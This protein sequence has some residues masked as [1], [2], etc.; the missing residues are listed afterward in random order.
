MKN[1]WIILGLLIAGFAGIFF[2]LHK[3]GT[4]SEFDRRRQAHLAWKQSAV[5]PS[6]VRPEEF[7]KLKVAPDQATDAEIRLPASTGKKDK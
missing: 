7:Q 6:M 4:P 3:D 1:V 2:F 5:E